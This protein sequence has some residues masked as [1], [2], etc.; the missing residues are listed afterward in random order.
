MKYWATES[1]NCSHI[2]LRGRD[3]GTYGA[4]G[5]VLQVVNWIAEDAKHEEVIIDATHCDSLRWI[6]EACSLHIIRKLL[7]VEI[8]VLLSQNPHRC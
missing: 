1:D 8:F 2:L 5:M 4:E 6:V 3:R 7:L